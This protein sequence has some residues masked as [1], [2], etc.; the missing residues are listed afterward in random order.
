MS[1][2]EINRLVELLGQE[3]RENPKIQAILSAMELNPAMHNIGVRLLRG[4]LMKEGIDAGDPGALPFVK[5]LPDGTV[6]IGPVMNGRLEGPTFSISEGTADNLQHVGAFGLT[7][8][9]K[10][11]ILQNISRHTMLRG[12]P[13]WVFDMENEC[14]HLVP[15]IAG[16]NQPV[17][18]QRSHLRICFFQPPNDSITPRSW[19]ETFSALLRGETFIRD[20]SQNLFNDALLQ[21]LK[22]KDALSGYPRYPSLY[23][24]LCHFQNL[25]LG[26]SEVRGKAWLESLVNRFT[27]LCHAFEETSH[28]TYSD[29]L[30]RLANKSVIFQFKG[31]RGI[32]LQFLTNFLIVWLACYKE[33]Q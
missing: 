7:R 30:Q 33:N 28:V 19:L 17:G 9:G 6:P 22:N 2:S 27:M 24:T 12:N 11:T 25:R 13:V 26:G 29:M 10:T 4:E 5:H 1:Q 3:G 31:V 16:P 15:S 23:E 21:L 14:S 8:Y 18:L 20:G 32:P